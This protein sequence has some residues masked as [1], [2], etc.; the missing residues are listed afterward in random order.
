[1]QPSNTPAPVLRRDQACH[2]LGV[3]PATLYRLSSAGELPAPIKLT[4]KAS[5]WLLSDLQAF[6]EK[7]AAAR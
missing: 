3:S 4:R 6:I 5:G 2:F 7:R 1:M